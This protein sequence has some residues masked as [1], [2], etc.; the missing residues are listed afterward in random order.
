MV[1]AR[2]SAGYQAAGRA[3]RVTK[4]TMATR[5]EV[6]LD[7]THPY[8]ADLVID[9]VCPSGESVRLHQNNGGDGDDIH[10][11]Y[12]TEMPSYGVLDRFIGEGIYGTW[13]LHAEDCGPYDQGV[14]NRWG[15]RITYAAG[16]TGVDDDQLPAV[17]TLEGNHPNPFNPSTAILFALPQSGPVELSVFDLAGRRIA[18]LVNEVRRAGRHE[19]VWDGRDVTGRAVATGT[20][21]YQ[22]KTDNFSKTRKLMLLK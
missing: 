14:I 13:R 11:W 18:V 12:P 3:T 19:A 17:L 10:A 4:I 22:L 8:L 20:Y 5:V 2:L 1:A 15:L 16:L 21:F 9:L 6:F 7:I